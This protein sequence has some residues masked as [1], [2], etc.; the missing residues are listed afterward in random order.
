MSELVQRSGL[1][2]K[3]V[4]IL[5]TEE[6]ATVER[7][8]PSRVGPAL[9]LVQQSVLESKTVVATLATQEAATVER[10]EPPMQGPRRS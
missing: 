1:E 5:A 8:E 10:S 7:S 2:S 3:T 9:Q 4:L 6:T